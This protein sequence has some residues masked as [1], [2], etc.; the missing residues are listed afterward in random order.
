METQ[1]VFCPSF[2]HYS[3][4]VFRQKKTRPLLFHLK[5]NRH[6]IQN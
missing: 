3:M 5:K 1:K 6:Y 4:L 2:T